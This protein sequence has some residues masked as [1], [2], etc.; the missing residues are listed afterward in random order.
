M[1]AYDPKVIE[2]F[3]SKLYARAESIVVST[4]VLGGLL[5]LLVGLIAGFVLGAELRLDPMIVV[6]AVIV[7]VAG[8]A[9]IGYM[10]GTER[11]FA[12]RL[13]AQQALCQVE[14]ERHVRVAVQR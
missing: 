13:Q 9:V 2:E 12:L 4:T 7:S 8:F 5:G 11:A 3:A 6:V 1:T 14:I 10:R